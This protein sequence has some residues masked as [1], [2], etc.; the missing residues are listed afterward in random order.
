MFTSAKV[1]FNWAYIIASESVF[2]L[3]LFTVALSCALHISFD[4]QN[5]L[6]NFLN[7]IRFVIFVGVWWAWPGHQIT[8]FHVE[9]RSA[10]S[11]TP[12]AICFKVKSSVFSDSIRFVVKVLSSFI[13]SAVSISTPRYTS[14]N[15]VC[16]Y[17][18]FCFLWCQCDKVTIVFGWRSK[19]M[20]F[21]GFPWAIIISIWSG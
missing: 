12:E 19:S 13:W 11:I 4:F 5:A 20:F 3:G 9:E 21:E 18:W 6:L 7:F 8:N 2:S 17:L 10:E 15:I 14:R 1:I 16:T